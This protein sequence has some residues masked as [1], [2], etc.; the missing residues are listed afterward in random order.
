MPKRD[1]CNH[2]QSALG[3]AGSKAPFSKTQGLHSLLYAGFSLRLMG[4]NK[5]QHSKRM[6]CF[7]QAGA[8]YQDLELLMV[9]HSVLNPTYRVTQSVIKHVI[10]FNGM[11][12]QLA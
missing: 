10:V 12:G 2:N 8:C 6:G 4:E 1:V 9:Y 3:P 5:E 7:P 11:G